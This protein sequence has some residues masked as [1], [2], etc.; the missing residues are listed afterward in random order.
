MLPKDHWTSHFRMYGSGWVIT[1]WWL[2]GSWRSV[3][4]NSSVYSCHLFLILSASVRSI[5]FL[6]FIVPIIAWYVPFVS[7]IVLKRLLVFRI[8]FFSLCFFVHLR[9][10]SHLSLLFSG[11]LHSVVYTLPF[12]LCLLLLFF[13]QLFV[14]PPQTITLPSCICF[15]L[16]WFWSP[17]PVQWYE[18]LSTVLQA[19]YHV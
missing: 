9:R 11:A 14:R 4:N 13:S 12:L 15:S 6:S 18:S 3:L 10:L 8:L 19:L 5:L 2:S 7:P 17:P 1:P 16:G